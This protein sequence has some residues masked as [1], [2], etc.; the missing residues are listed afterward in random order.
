MARYHV[1]VNAAVAGLNLVAGDKVI[2]LTRNPCFEFSTTADLTAEELDA[3]KATLP[4]WAADH[5]VK[6]AV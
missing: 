4:A 2:A 5:L 3:I 1:D 6:E